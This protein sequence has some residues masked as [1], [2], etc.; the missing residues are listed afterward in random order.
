MNFFSVGF[1]RDRRCKPQP[2]WLAGNV[3]LPSHP[4]D[5]VS[6][7]HEKAVAKLALTAIHKGKN[8][9]P[10]PVGN[11][12]QHSLVALS[13]VFGFEQIKIGGELNF[14]LRIARS[15]IQVHY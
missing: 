13:H 12:K 11:F 7:A 8:P 5:G 1:M 15:L 3:V 2:P 6:L 14:T 4:G 10:A 9:A